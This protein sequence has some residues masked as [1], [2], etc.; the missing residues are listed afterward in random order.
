MHTSFAQLCG[1]THGVTIRV[2]TRGETVRGK[3]Q[4]FCV[5]EHYPLR[6]VASA[7]PDGLTF[8]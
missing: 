6:G 1:H 3:H 4:R 2:H 8:F 5:P 7:K